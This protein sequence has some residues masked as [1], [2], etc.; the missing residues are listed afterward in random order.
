MAIVHLGGSVLDYELD[1]LRKILSLLDVELSRVNA[2]LRESSDPESY[3]LCDL[4]EFLIGS[5]FVAVQRYLNATRVNLGFSKESYNRAPMFNQHIATVGAINAIS[6]HWKHSA[7]WDEA[8]RNGGDPSAKGMSA[9]TLKDLESM[10]ELGEYPC[11]NAL[12]LML[13]EKDL[14]LS[15]LIPVLAVWR[16]GLL[17]GSLHAG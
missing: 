13:P 17:A 12:A 5:G 7:D 10:G 2:E 9:R 15:N 3:G 14:A 1:L 4:G 16:G 8:E 11:A 6:N